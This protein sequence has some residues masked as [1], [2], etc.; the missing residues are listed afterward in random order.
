M[1]DSGTQ[2]RSNSQARAWRL[3][4]GLQA[5]IVAAFIMAAYLVFEN[6]RLGQSSWHT[7]NLLASTLLGPQVA[8]ARFGVATLVGYSFHVLLSGAQGLLFGVLVP[9]RLGTLWSANVGIAYSLAWYV[10]V[11]RGALGAWNPLLLN[12]GPRAGMIFGYFIFGAA[13]GF[14]A[15]YYRTLARPLPAASFIEP[16][17]PPQSG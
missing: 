8:G 12:R 16:A 17:L 11:F 14:Y 3:L 4:A 10:I 9:P 13:L 6:L 2:E 1:P 5:G 15:R 7:P